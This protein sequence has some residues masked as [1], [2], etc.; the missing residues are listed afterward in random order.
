MQG[1]KNW[2]LL[3]EINANCSSEALIGWKSLKTTYFPLWGRLEGA[4]LWTLD[5]ISAAR[6]RNLSALVF[7][8]YNK[9]NTYC[10][11]LYV[12]TCE[13]WC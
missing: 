12:L 10:A 5:N 13:D 7:S 4:W 3:K 8:V 11:V 2:I 9:W 1:G 6:V